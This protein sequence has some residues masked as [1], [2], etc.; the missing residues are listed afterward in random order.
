M[1]VLQ[2]SRAIRLS[3]SHTAQPRHQ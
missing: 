3:I 1:H 2:R